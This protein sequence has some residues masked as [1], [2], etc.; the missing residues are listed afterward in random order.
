MRP[1]SSER[2]FATNVIVIDGC[3]DLVVDFDAK[4]IGYAGMSKTVFQDKMDLPGRFLGARLK[5]GA[6]AE[7]TGLPAKAAMDTY[8]PLERADANFDTAHFFS[9]SFEEMK[10]YLTSYLRQRADGKTP[11]RFVTLFDELSDNPPATTAELYRLLHFSPRQC[12]RLFLKH[13]GITPQMALS[14]LRFQH[15]LER[16]TSDE[17]TPSGLLETAAY[18]DQSHFIKDFKRNIGL[19]PFEYLDM[20]KMSHIYNA[21]ASA[22]AIIDSYPKKQE[23]HTMQ[24]NQTMLNVLVRKDYG[25]CFDFYTEK[26]GLVPTWGDRSGPY[27]SFAV[28]EGE[29]PCFAIF[30]I[31]N[32]PMFKGY[33]VPCATEQ[34]DTLMGAI[35][36][37]DVDADYKRIKEAGVEFL[38]EPQTIPEWGMRCT[39]FRDPE[40]NLF[41]LYGEGEM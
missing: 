1:R 16:L 41:G 7:L 27:T 28:K 20:Q 29:P 36:T 24:F 38:G 2:A 23:E 22:S 30:A 19:T 21:E 8:L 14:V 37:T 18:Y 15:C 33:T 25:A 17:A 40:G 26:L 13:Y 3:I 12:Q 34:S 9:L 10:P 5:P 6:F 31:A 35:P 32:M 4:H 11:G 39:Y